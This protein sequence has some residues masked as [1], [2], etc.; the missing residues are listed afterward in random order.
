[1][2]NK[3]VN[4]RYTNKMHIL[5]FETKKLFQNVATFINGLG[6]GILCRRSDYI[7]DFSLVHIY[8]CTKAAP[9]EN[10]VIGPRDIERRNICILQKLV[11]SSYSPMLLQ[12]D[13]ILLTLLSSG[14]RQSCQFRLK[15]IV[16]ERSWN[17]EGENGGRYD[18]NR[19][20]G[21]R[22]T[23]VCSKAA[24]YPDTGFI[25]KMLPR[26]TPNWSDSLCVSRETGEPVN[27]SQINAIYVLRHILCIIKFR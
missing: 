9:K 23:E 20:I 14:A 12:A 21:K 24:W 25:Q 8:G 17:G 6:L 19:G 11:Y 1:M 3:W 2:M 18:N 16:I 10:K 4:N 22:W 15:G 13:G 27:M 7:L 5:S 26:T